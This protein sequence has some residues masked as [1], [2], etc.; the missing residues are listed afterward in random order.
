MKCPGQQQRGSLLSPLF[1]EPRPSASG[2]PLKARSP[3]GPCSSPR[4]DTLGPHARHT[5]GQGETQ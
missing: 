3:P 5:S 2:A 4:P 1:S